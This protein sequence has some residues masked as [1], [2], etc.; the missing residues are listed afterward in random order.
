MNTSATVEE[1]DNVP[2]VSIGLPVYNGEQFLARAIESHLAQTFTDFELV[3]TDNCSTDGTEQIC[4]DF[5]T[6]DSRVRYI[7]NEENL[8]AA[9][10]FQKAFHEST[11]PYFRWA[12]HDDYIAPTYLER[13]VEVLDREPDAAIVFTGMTIVRD[14]ESV[15][16][17]SV[18]R[19]P[20]STADTALKRF[21]S[22]LWRLKDCTSPVFGLAHRELLEQTGLVRNS[23]EPDR[24]LMAE[25]SMFGG[26]HQIE[27]LLFYRGLADNHYS[28]DNWAWLNPK[29]RGTAKRGWLRVSQHYLNAIR[30]A[31]VS[32]VTKWLMR[33]DMALAFAWRRPYFRIR[34]FW[35]H[36]I[37]PPKHI[38]EY[39]KTHGTTN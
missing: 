1:S 16:R 38:R 23:P 12:A 3:I 25:L 11:G 36:K 30:Q 6:K 14:D 27:D 2:K 35:R 37:R 19:I 20:G 31:D 24:I 17:H 32:G 21:H 29:N 18:Q 9:G 34:M 39:A 4:K 22:V 8:G 15:R 7:R 13:C 28:R 5:A 26:I 10:N 33:L